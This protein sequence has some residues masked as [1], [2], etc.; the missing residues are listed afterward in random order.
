[1]KTSI[2]FFI[3]FF[4]FVSNIHSQVFVNQNATGN[5]DGT[6]WSD[7]FSNLQDAINNAPTGSQL[8]IATGNYTPSL[9]SQ[10]DSNFFSIDNTLELYGGF[11]GTETMLSQR[12]WTTNITTLNGDV[13]GDDVEFNFNL[14]RTDNAIHVMVIGSTASGTII[15]GLTIKGGD[16]RTDAVPNGTTD[17][18]PW[19]A[20]GI[21]V[22]SP[23]EIK[24]CNIQ[25]CS[26]SFGSAFYYRGSGNNNNELIMENCIIQNNN[27]VQGAVT[28]FNLNSPV[29]RNSIFRLNYASTFGGG[30]IF[31]NTNGF[32]EDCTFE[33]NENGSSIGGGI[34]IFQNSGN[35]IPSPLVEI[36]KSEFLS[37][38]AYF[39]GGLCFNNFFPNSQIILDSCEFKKN[40]A[41]SNTTTGGLAGGLFI[42]N[43]EDTFSG[44]NTSLS[45]TITNCIFEEN[46]ALFGGGA[47]FFS[48][49]DGF[50]LTI[51]NTEF[52]DNIANDFG[53]GVVVGNTLA[54]FD[55]CTFQD[56]SANTSVGGGLFIFNNS[57]NTNP[58]PT[59][60]VLNSTFENNRAFT[61]GGL[62]FNNFF[63]KSNIIIDGCDFLRNGVN[64]TQGAGGGALLQNVQ[65]LDPNTSLS[66]QISNSNFEENLAGQ[67]GGAQIFSNVDSL[68]LMVSNT[69]FYK[70]TSPY[71]GGMDITSGGS[72]ITANLFET[73]FMENNADLFAGG[74]L[75][76]DVD[77]ISVKKSKFTNNF[78]KAGATALRSRADSRLTLETV[79]FNDNDG[80]ST[81]VNEDS[82]WMINV[83][84]IDNTLGLR[85]FEEGYLE[86]QNSI[87]SNNTNNFVQEQDGTV[88]TKGGNISSDTSLVNA[89]VGYAGYDDFNDTD[90][91][92]D[93]EYIPQPF[94]LAIDR[95][96]PSGVTLT[97]DVENHDRIQGLAIDAGALE[98]SFSTNTDELITLD[99]QIYPNPFVDHIIISDFEEIEDLR[100]LDVMGRELNQLPIQNTIHLNKNL[101]KGIY[102]LKIKTNSQFFLK[103][104][105]KK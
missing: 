19:R 99:L 82:I 64:G 85:Q 36:R 42:Q 2:T 75:L 53:G 15:D 56:N 67:G 89:L 70:N 59:T 98:S 33:E 40:A 25:Q 17:F 39:G 35:T 29:I 32:V 38:T 81:I 101:P 88:V 11:A 12:D 26:G 46:G 97:Q 79:L 65:G 24:N 4:L 69:D 84:M 71:G 96:N 52:T 76:F 7:A 18:S 3:V 16:A 63:P 62:A 51:E 28:L 83:T 48:T 22:N 105:E 103:K 27:S 95:G 92:L 47:Y 90:P 68:D 66:I 6:S 87:F 44:A 77:N 14:F 20:G 21:W 74:L 78:C 72:I 23:M 49:D 1:M 80:N 104:L 9:S 8:W 94:S 34:L 61:G 55:G 91:L 93:M 30:L 60:E 31:G 45:A 86:L 37:N 100:L 73:N 43:L 54:T 13:N 50:N 5:N 10:P 102:F 41:L 58:E 57:L